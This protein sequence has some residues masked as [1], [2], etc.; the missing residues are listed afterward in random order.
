ME[1]LEQTRAFVKTHENYSISE[2]A[3]PAFSNIQISILEKKWVMVSKNKTPTIHFVIRH[4]KLRDSI[5]NMIVPI[6]D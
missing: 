6:V 1:H 5:E 4:P 3:S 2:N